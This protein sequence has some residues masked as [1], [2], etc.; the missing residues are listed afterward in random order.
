MKHISQTMAMSR[1][2][3][4]IP[5][6]RG[7]CSQPTSKLAE[8]KATSL[9]PARLHIHPE[10]FITSTQ[11][12]QYL[13]FPGES[14]SEMCVCVLSVR[15]LQRGKSIHKIVHNIS[16]GQ[17]L[18]T[19]ALP[20][21][22]PLPLLLLTQRRT[23][24]H[25]HERSTARLKPRR[26]PPQRLALPPL[27]LF[28]PCAEMGF[29]AFGLCCDRCAPVGLG[30]EYVGFESEWVDELQGREKGGERVNQALGFTGRMKNELTYAFMFSGRGW[31][32]G[33]SSTW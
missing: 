18:P 22:L 12:A 27:L 2:V 16:L 32:S 24:L 8:R 33:G 4:S 28:L 14:E 30:V 31:M 10:T 23:S 20:L 13:P 11:Y 6:R 26:D 5:G 19:S 17:I 25:R 1:T 21:F 29:V 9:L 7:S 15:V 3:S